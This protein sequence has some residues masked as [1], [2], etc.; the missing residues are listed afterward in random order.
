MNDHDGYTAG[1]C[2]KKWRCTNNAAG[3][4]RTQ[5]NCQN[6]IKHV[7][8]AE[9]THARKADHDD[10][11]DEHD[12]RPGNDFAQADFFFDPPDLSQVH[13][14][15]FAAGHKKSAILSHGPWHKIVSD[16][17]KYVKMENDKSKK[18]NNPSQMAGP[19]SDRQGV[20][21]APGEEENEGRVENVVADTQRAKGKV[22]GDPSQAS[23]QPINE[24]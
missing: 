18:V 10:H 16:L 20:D 1:N 24:P 5:K 22:D 3:Q 9:G 17:G 6:V 14:W 4:Y 13:K 15:F 12:G 21:K 19:H 23:D 11:Q 2:R 7:A 8:F